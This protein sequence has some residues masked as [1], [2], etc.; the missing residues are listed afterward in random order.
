MTSQDWMLLA[1][2]FIAAVA[3][4][5]LAAVETAFRAISH[6]RVEQMVDDGLKGADALLEL[7]ED[8]APS[9]NIAL[10]LRLAC[11]M[12]SII[13][14][15]VVAFTNLKPLWLQIAA[16]LG[17][18]LLLSFLFWGVAPRTLG[19]QHAYGLAR[20]TAGI[21]GKLG[22]FFGPFL[23]LLIWL[24][25]V[26]TPGKG[27]V[28]GP[29]ASE[30]ELRELVDKATEVE[31]IE[32]D[33]QRMIHSVFE[34]GDTIVREVMVPRLDMVTIEED[35]TVRQAVSLAL[36]SGFSRIPVT[37]PDGSADH[38]VGVIYLKDLIRRVY[39]NASA[40]T[41]ELVSSV[42]RE[43]EWC[44]DSK[45]IDEL[46]RDMQRTRT[47]LMLVLDE[48]GG[49]A[50]LVSI[51]DILEEIV[52][53]IVDEYDDEIAPVVQLGQDRYRV[54]TRL[55]LADLGELFGLKVDD[56]DVETVGGLM[57]KL[58]NM[59]PIAGSVVQ[60]EGLEL[61][62]ERSLGRRNQLRTV[63]VTLADQAPDPADAATELAAEAARRQS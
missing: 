43:V 41:T 35:K 19:R 50:G 44:P 47:H 10:F 60:W 18:M 62:A 48:F 5:I 16:P 38:I 54:T 32:A 3:A 12:V 13:F 23:A 26:L 31:V 29:F 46:L 59:V 15:A 34:F 58:L 14:V 28:D 56:E 63:L 25:N 40:Q 22:W 27:Y 61:T 2:A 20:R 57:A 55:D 33:E 52:G 4:G 53:E 11:E 45:P 39:D 24:G 1:I 8:P 37:Q 30:I 9:V 21:I 7:A 17:S 51:E 42:M 6:A 36:R 49:T